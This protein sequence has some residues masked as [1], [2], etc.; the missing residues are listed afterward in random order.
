[1]KKII[2]GTAFALALG[3]IAGPLAL[4]QPASA[5]AP[6]SGA[7]QG[8]GPGGMGMGPHGMGGMGGKGPGARGMGPRFGAG[9][10]PGWSMMTPEERAAHQAAMR[11]AKTQEEC[12]AVRDQHHTEM[13]ARAQAKGA[14]MPAA[15]RRDVCAGLPKK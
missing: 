9:V 15:P 14:S 6:G 11:N 8:M 7:S 10:T 3:G 4:A 2:L 13:A 1:M 12:V 5:P